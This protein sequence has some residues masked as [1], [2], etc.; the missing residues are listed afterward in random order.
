[1]MLP[2]TP[3]SA[4]IFCGSN[5]SMAFA[6]LR[7]TLALSLN[8][9]TAVLKVIIPLACKT[10]QHLWGHEEAVSFFIHSFPS[11]CKLGLLRFP[12]DK[13]KKLPKLGAYFA[14]K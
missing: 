4:S 11:I 5:F 10:H 13:W 9:R 14:A 12:V 2:S 7:E 8:Y 3:S 1:M 6:L